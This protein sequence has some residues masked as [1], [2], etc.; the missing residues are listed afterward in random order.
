M[1]LDKELEFD[2]FFQGIVRP[3]Q[4]FQHLLK[5]QFTVKTA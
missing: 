1:L 3:K 5:T 2:R 4:Y